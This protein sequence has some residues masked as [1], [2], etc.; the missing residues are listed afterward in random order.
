MLS[1]LCPTVCYC[2]CVIDRVWVRWQI[3]KWW[4]AHLSKWCSFYNFFHDSNNH[5]TYTIPIS[6]SYSLQEPT[7]LPLKRAIR[8]MSSNDMHVQLVLLQWSK[9]LKSVDNKLL[10]FSYNFFF[11][12]N[13]H[14]QNLSHWPINC[15]QIFCL[16]LITY[17]VPFMIQFIGLLS[18]HKLP[19]ECH[20]NQLGLSHSWRSYAENLF[21]PLIQFFTLSVLKTLA[22]SNNPGAWIIGSSVSLIFCMSLGHHHQAYLF[23]GYLLTS[24]V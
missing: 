9:P 6:H 1:I 10:P 22:F 18:H 7:S 21:F 4:H 19:S 3:M 24:F 8:S 20:G 23:F 13:Y 17:Y 11:S 12:N 2:V 5:N 15:I 14:F 16:L